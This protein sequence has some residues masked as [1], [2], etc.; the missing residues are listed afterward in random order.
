[1]NMPTCDVVITTRNRAAA[2][3]HCLEGLRK[4]SVDG[5]GVIVVDDCSDEPM[6]RSV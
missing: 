5:F 4:Q 6:S 2:L 3:R 1:M